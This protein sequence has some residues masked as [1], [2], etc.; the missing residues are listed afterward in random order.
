MSTDTITLASKMD[1]FLLVVKYWH[2]R[3]EIL[4]N[5]KARLEK[6]KGKILGVILNERRFEIPGFIY[7]RL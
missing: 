2:T 7:R 3:R 5:V 1:G 4:K 6:A